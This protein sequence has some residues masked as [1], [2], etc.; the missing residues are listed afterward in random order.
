MKKVIPAI[1]I[2][3]LLLIP[4]FSA[5]A[6]LIRL[7]NGRQVATSAYW[8]EGTRIFFYTTGGIGGI[9][10]SEIAGVESDEAENKVTAVIVNKGKEEKAL[11]LTSSP[12]EKLQEQPPPSQISK[13]KI[14]LKPYTDEKDRMIVE[15]DALMEELRAATNRKDFIAKEKIREEIRVKS[16][17]IYQLTDEVKNKNQGKLPAGWWEK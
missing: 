14:D 11:P 10:R 5:A 4:D 15:L 16:G 9:E 17:Q 1:M 12:T 2:L 3:L 6:Y 13:E 8:F 7:K